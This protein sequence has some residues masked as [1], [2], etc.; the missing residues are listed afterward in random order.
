MR[1]CADDGFAK[2]VGEHGEGTNGE[3]MLS[4]EPFGYF[5]RLLVEGIGKLLLC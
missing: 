1:D 3:I 4:A 2:E 5:A